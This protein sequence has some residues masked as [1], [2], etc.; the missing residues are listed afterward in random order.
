MKL[1]EIARNNQ[2]EPGRVASNEL[3]YLAY[4][5]MGQGIL[6]LRTPFYRDPEIVAIFQGLGDL[7]ERIGHPRFISLQAYIPDAEGGRWYVANEGLRSLAVQLQATPSLIANP[8]WKSKLIDDLMNATDHLHRRELMAV[9]LSLES[10]MVTGSKEHRLFLLPPC[11][12][13][14]FAKQEIWKTPR[15]YLPEEL[16]NTLEVDKRADLYG[17]GYIIKK[18][19][20]NESIPHI[21]SRMVKS[22]TNG[23]IDRRPESVDAMRRMMKD[24]ARSKIITTILTAIV[25]TLIL[26]IL[27]GWFLNEPEPTNNLPKP[28]GQTDSIPKD[29]LDATIGDKRDVFDNASI[30]DDPQ[31]A[32]IRERAHSYLA[33]TVYLDQDTAYSLSPETMQRQR[34]GIIATQNVFKIDFRRE[35]LVHVKRMYGGDAM[36]RDIDLYNE[37]I[38]EESQELQDIAIRLSE[39][40]GLELSTGNNLADEVVRE[41][42]NEVRNR[43]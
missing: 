12:P 15:A 32:A 22:A 30:Y 2:R 27:V 31:E 25:G 3:M 43:Q 40:Y 39:K 23:R 7:M 10:V 19:Y 14:L 5:E 37:I 35:A 18:L 26:G 42:T 41:L 9:D 13:F 20:F 28:G 17:I 11:S 21:Y 29:A 1:E 16:Q 6:R 8:E 36:S 38:R 24:S 4:D 34:D 33:D